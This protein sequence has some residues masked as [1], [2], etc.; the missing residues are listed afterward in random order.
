MIKS[1]LKNSTKALDC[2]LRD[3]GYCNAWQFG[4]ENISKIIKYLVDSNVDIIE[5]GF[6]SEK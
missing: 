1:G 3:G 6:I 2:T 4:K 5:C